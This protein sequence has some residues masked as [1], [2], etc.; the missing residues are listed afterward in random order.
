MVR[1]PE[2]AGEVYTPLFQ[3]PHTDL[4]SP[5]EQSGGQT[6]SL[7]LD[8]AARAFRF[9]TPEEGAVFQSGFAFDIETT[10]IS[11]DEPWR[12]PDA[13]L[14][15]AFDGQTGCFVS[16][17]HFSAFF[18]AHPDQRVI[19]HHATFDLAVIHKA[20]PEVNIY[21]HVESDNVWDTQLL[22]RLYS[23][24]TVGHTAFGKGQSTLDRC[25]S[26]YL[27]LDLPK[28]VMD[29]SG[30]EVRTSYDQWLN[31]E[32]EDIEPIYLEYL[33]KDA[34]VTQWV[35][36]ALQQRIQTVLSGNNHVWGFVSRDWL[37]EQNLRWGPL[38]HHIQL[39]AA[40]VLQD[41]T[42]N[43]LHMDQASRDEHRSKIEQLSREYLTELARHGWKPGEGSNAKLQEILGR[44]DVPGT[45]L[46]LQK[47]K[48]GKYKADRDT[49]TE[50][51]GREPFFK[52]LLSYRETEKLQSAF[53]DKMGRPVLHPSFDVLKTT[54]RTSSFG[55][56]NAQNLPRDD[57][58]RACFVPSPG[59]VFID[60]DYSTVELATLA[61]SCL[62][63]FGLESK[64][65]AAINAEQDLHTL[66]AARVAGKQPEDITGEERQ[67]AKPINFGKPG[68]MGNATLK[69]YANASYGIELND[70]Q[71]E[72]LADT[73]FEMFPE[74]E[75]FLS[76]D[77]DSGAKVAAYLDLTPDNFAEETGN[78]S[79]LDHPN[80]S[81]RAHDPHKILGLMCIKVMGHRKPQR[82]S[83]APYTD[84][85]KD[86]FWHRLAERDENFPKDVQGA[87]Q[88]HE[89][90]LD[91]RKSILKHICRESVYTLSG[92]LR[93]K[94]TYCARH[95]TVFQGLAADGA[96][97]ALWR[98]WRDGFRIVNFI[99]DEMLVEVPEDVDLKQQAER[100]RELMIRGMKEVVP[101]VRIDVEYAASHRWYK[102]AKPV[103]DEKTGALMPWEPKSEDVC[104]I[105][106]NVDTQP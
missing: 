2:V 25:S 56:I 43:G 55:E 72:R 29:A 85:E 7:D 88:W 44:L 67:Q 53:L 81:D 57:R 73:W 69:Q 13:V 12:V 51:A 61:Q 31:R 37:E 46:R 32:S 74:M 106:Q 60:A 102:K 68:G 103:F 66:I 8:E 97:L 49:L 27:G 82:Q 64:M 24:A 20:A 59:H 10:C 3:S 21:D 45:G 77:E 95:N 100:I 58:I 41:T 6:T 36:T 16:W 17:K 92:R 91:L 93:A 62:K 105:V 90:S 26:V 98:L 83:G 4:P 75:A 79:F 35:F 14:G 1:S 48:T 42:R 65:A 80:N 101:D 23:L 5:V 78:R 47:T 9:W 70:Q 50:L 15:A 22:H 19:F 99:H 11:D 76:D 89:P 54:G 30:N 34:I 96:K 38:T 104:S 40:I 84:A 94:A 87:I 33:A 52:T 86:Y 28:D 71:V 39:K 63:Q 18:A